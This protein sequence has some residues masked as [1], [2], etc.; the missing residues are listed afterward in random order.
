MRIIS[1]ALVSIL[2]LAGCIPRPSE[3]I[4]SFKGV[5]FSYSENKPI[6]KRW[7]VMLNFELYPPPKTYIMTD[8]EQR[9]IAEMFKQISQEKKLTEQP[10]D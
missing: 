3:K 9:E 1:T 2:L 6:E 8:K 4:V 7:K 5:N 10:T